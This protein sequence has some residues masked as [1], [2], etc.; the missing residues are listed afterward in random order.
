MEQATIVEA[1]QKKLNSR[2]RDLQMLQELIEQRDDIL[3]G[4]LGVPAAAAVSIIPGTEHGE[5][6]LDVDLADEIEMYFSGKDAPV[7]PLEATPPRAR[8]SSGPPSDLHIVTD[9]ISPKSAKIREL[10]ITPK[11]TSAFLCSLL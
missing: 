2:D 9:V 1:L 10:L 4:R 11:S 3:R 7:V 5:P 8:L 6:L